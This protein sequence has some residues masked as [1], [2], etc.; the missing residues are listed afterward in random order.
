MEPTEKE[1]I[2]NNNNKKGGSKGKDGDKHKLPTPPTPDS[3]MRGTK[4][5]PINGKPKDLAK[6]NATGRKYCDIYIAKVNVKTSS[7]K[8]STSAP[9]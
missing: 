1:F 6:T 9:L 7:A 2:I 8:T 3:K 4:I 5:E